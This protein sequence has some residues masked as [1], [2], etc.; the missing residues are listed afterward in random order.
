MKPENQALISELVGSLRTLVRAVDLDSQEMSKQFGLTAPQSSVLRLLVNNGSMS[1]AELSRQ[2]YVTPSNITGIIDR[3]ERKGYVQRT[4][5]QGDRRVTLI[6][7]TDSGKQLSK[8]LPDPIEKKII[9]ELADLPPERVRV[10]SMA[11]RQILEM[12]GS[13]DSGES[14]HGLGEGVNQRKFDPYS[15]SK[16]IG[17]DNRQAKGEGNGID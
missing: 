15:G 13:R 9:S 1:S 7:L 4:R 16:R 6:T 5:K 2:L 8:I 11:M 10:L 14:P 3:L 12:I 17:P